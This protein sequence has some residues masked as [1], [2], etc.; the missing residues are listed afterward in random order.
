MPENMQNSEKYERASD[1]TDLLGEAL[2]Y[3][4]NA[5]ENIETAIE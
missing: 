5:V 2:E 1:T 4:V 3:F